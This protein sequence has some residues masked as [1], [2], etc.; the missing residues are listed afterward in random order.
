MFAVDFYTLIVRLL[1]PFLRRPVMIAWLYRLIHPVI[2]LYGQFLGFRQQQLMRTSCT[3][4]VI[5]LEWLLNEL[6]DPTGRGIYILTNGLSTTDNFIYSETDSA[7]SNDL[8]SE[9]DAG[10]PPLYL[11]A[12]ID[13]FSL[14]HFTVFVPVALVFD[15]VQLRAVVDYYRLAGKRFDVQTY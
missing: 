11:Y 14:I 2:S 8:Y 6:F 10:M 5:S 15:P 3:G 13:Y 12:E 9:S 1:P 4:Q 7:A